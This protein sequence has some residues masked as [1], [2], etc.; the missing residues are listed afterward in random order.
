MMST[1]I[2][3]D[4]AAYWR[5]HRL[6]GYGIHL[7]TFLACPADIL[8]WLDAGEYRPLLTRQRLIAQRWD[9][10]CR[11]DRPGLVDQ[12]RYLCRAGERGLIE[13][14]V[15]TRFDRY[16]MAREGGRS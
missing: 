5:D 8:A 3:T 4:L 15:Q 6:S 13:R 1:H 7:D 9:E 2:L 10:E 16:A 12:R 14:R 11:S